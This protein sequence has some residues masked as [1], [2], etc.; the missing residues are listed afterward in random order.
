M[1][2][3]CCEHEPVI[4]TIPIDSGRFATYSS[5]GFVDN[6]IVP[7]LFLD[8]TGIMGDLPTLYENGRFIP[9]SS[10]AVLQ[11]MIVSMDPTL[12]PG[13][14]IASIKI[15]MAF[16][17]LAGG[18]FE[19]RGVN[20]LGNQPVYPGP[21]FTSAAVLWDIPP[22]DGVTWV[23]HTSPELISIFNGYHAAFGAA[24]FAR[25][26]FM[27]LFLGGVFCRDFVPGLH[28]DT[29]RPFILYS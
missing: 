14:G 13:P 9:L 23:R 8:H 6:P 5:F 22:G 24:T 3:C 4:P 27:P 11:G 10:R 20:Y 28:P 15:A 2:W 29:Q 16:R 26:Q 18:T 12:G 19:M 7:P 17:T 1:L 25:F 21:R